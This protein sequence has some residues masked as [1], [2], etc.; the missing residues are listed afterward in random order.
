MKK[1]IVDLEK[2]ADEKT[3]RFMRV[4]LSVKDKKKAYGIFLKVAEGKLSYEQ[5]L[6]ELRKLARG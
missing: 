4:Y 6:K 2:E 1:S 3:E 5:G